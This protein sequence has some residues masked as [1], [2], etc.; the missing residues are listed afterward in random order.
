MC[1]KEIIEKKVTNFTPIHKKNRYPIYVP[2]KGRAF[3]SGFTVSALVASGFDYFIV[4]EPQDYDEYGNYYSKHVLCKMEEN[5]RGIAY[6]RNFCKKHSTENGYAY[7]W[8]ADDNIKN[9]A[10]R[11]DKKNVPCT[12]AE[13]ILPVEEVIDSYHNIGIAG[14]SH[15]MFA[16]AKSTA[17]DFNKQIYSCFLVNNSV[18]Y[19]WRSD[20]VEDTD[21]SLQVLHGGYSTILFNRL[22]INK[23]ATM[24]IKGGNTDGE[25]AGMGR[26]NR[27][28]QLQR[29]WPGANFVITNQYN[30]V[31][32]MPSR[33]W[34]SFKQTPETKITNITLENFL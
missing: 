27:S 4:V 3:L 32:V 26:M 28:L 11:R 18:N 5:D 21:Y 24:T 17:V 25:Y 2:S 13:C 14:L 33:I 29:D 16:F 8:Q 6:A 12:A 22:L 31:K 1:L 19:Y 15:T 30:R 23:A 7:H 20:T 9:F 34:R 10:I